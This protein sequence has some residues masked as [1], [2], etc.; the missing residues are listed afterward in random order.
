MDRNTFGK[1]LSYPHN[2]I[3]IILNFQFEKQNISW[4]HIVD[5]YEWDLGVNEAVP[6]LRK[7]W[8]LREE[9]IKLSTRLRMQVKLAAQVYI[10][11]QKTT[12]LKDIFSKFQ[13]LQVFIRNKKYTSHI[14]RAE[15]KSVIIFLMFLDEILL[16]TEGVRMLTKSLL[17]VLKAHH[18]FI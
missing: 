16:K 18:P 11:D 3:F 13:L 8:K 1:F 14:N 7:L 10:Y 9:H 6:G 15:N 4:S 2:T 17:S 12:L 5:C